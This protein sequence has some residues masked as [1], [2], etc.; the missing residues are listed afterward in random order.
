[1]IGTDVNMHAI[2][3]SLSHGRDEKQNAPLFDAS[4]DIP[5]TP[6]STHSPRSHAHHNIRPGRTDWAQR[7]TAV[8]NI[9][10]D[11]EAARTN[12]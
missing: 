10:M 6:R 5:L 4:Q 11:K 3:F 9:R 2:S 8:A 12:R 7:R 1:M